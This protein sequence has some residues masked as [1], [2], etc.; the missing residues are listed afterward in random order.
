MRRRALIALVLPAAA[1]AFAPAAE[2][3]PGCHSRRC[4]RHAAE[5][6]KRH[7]ACRA[8]V[9]RRRAARAARRGELVEVSW[10]GPGLYGQP[11]ACGGTLSAGTRG[12]AHKSL[13]CGTPVTLT[14]RGRSVTVP[15]VDRGPYVAGRTFDLTSE[16][17]R[18]LGFSG[19]GAM[20]ASVG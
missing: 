3:S 9:E 8:R 15:V 6:C 17:A 2:A 4:F 1:A 20:L 13:P 10:Y 7:P 5:L 18:E 14:Y 19:V 16:T 12:V 11:L